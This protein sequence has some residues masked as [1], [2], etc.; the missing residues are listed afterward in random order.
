[1]VREQFT[2]ACP[3]ELSVYLNERSPKTLDELVTWAEQYLMAHN[4]KLSSSQLRRED[5][6][7][8]SRGETRKDPA[9]RCSVSDVVVKDIVPQNA[10]PRCQMGVAERKRDTK[11]DFHAKSA[12]VMGM[13]PEIVALH[14]AITIHSVPDQTDP[15]L[16]HQ[17][18]VRDVWLRFESC[19]ELI[20]KKKLKYW[21]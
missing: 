5:V 15:S 6:K 3:K 9:A 10:Y 7:N 2:N 18:I 4:K 12:A 20:Q 13:K 1:M 19:L 8:G 16:H 21:S 17:F 14:R 11:E